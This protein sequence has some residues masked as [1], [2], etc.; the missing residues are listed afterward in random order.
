MSRIIQQFR[1]DLMPLYE[2]LKKDCGANDDLVP[3]LIQFGKEFPIKENCGIMFYGRATNGWEHG[4][5]DFDVFFSEFLQRNERGW[6]R[7][8]Q[9]V[10]VE[11]H[12]KNPKYS[13]DT[14]KSQFWK[15][16]RHISIEK[17][18]NKWYDK[19]CWSN[20]CKVAP[21]EEGNPSDSLYYDTL[22]HNCE[23]FKLEIEYWSPK[24]VILF[25]DGYKRDNKT[26]IDWTSSY[27][28]YINKNKEVT[29]I[30]KIIWDS[31]YPGF[32]IWVYRIGE[33]YYILTI[34]PQRGK[35]W[36]HMKVLLEIMDNLSK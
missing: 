22:H 13:Y 31:D 20:I 4:T 34:H 21:W 30:K 3:F 7:Q 18:G 36:L 23:I 35:V 2:E 5:W 27:L 17:Y 14:S 28:R 9:L 11:Y 1:N 25:T 16:I 24:F 8:D 29:P 32:E 6:N 26:R 12:W 15:I 10:W 33:R 19:I